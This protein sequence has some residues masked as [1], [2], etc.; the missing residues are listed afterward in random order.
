MKQSRLKEII[1]KKLIKW[2]DN[3]EINEREGEGFYVYP[4]KDRFLVVV[5]LPDGSYREDK[6][7]SLKERMG[8]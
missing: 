1:R 6:E 7:K 8:N 2:L 3:V 4:T 5:H